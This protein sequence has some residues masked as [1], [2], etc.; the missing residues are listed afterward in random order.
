MQPSLGVMVMKHDFASNVM[1][2][3]GGLRIVVD[4][5]SAKAVVMMNMILHAVEADSEEQLQPIVG[6]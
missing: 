3:L 1:V 6:K 5:L 4:S 2:K